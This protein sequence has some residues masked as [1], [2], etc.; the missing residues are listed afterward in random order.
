MLLELGAG[1]QALSLAIH[2]THSKRHLQTTTFHTEGAD[3]H[4]SQFRASQEF[5]LGKIL[6]VT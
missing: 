2:D 3:I 6:H 4:L 5:N 1:I